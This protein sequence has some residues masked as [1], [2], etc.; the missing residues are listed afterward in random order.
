MHDVRSTLR[1]EMS[2]HDLRALTRRNDTISNNQDASEASFFGYSSYSCPFDLRG[3]LLLD[4][5]REAVLEDHAA[6]C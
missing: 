6:W 5:A 2:E 1:E 3:D 4:P